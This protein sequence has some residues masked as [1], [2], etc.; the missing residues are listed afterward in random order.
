MI[1]FPY[2]LRRRMMLVNADP[3]FTFDYSGGFTDNRKADGT[4]KVK[5]TSSGTLTILTGEATVSA[6]ILGS[7]GGA[8]LWTNTA[9]PSRYRYYGASG[10]GGG[11]QTI[12]VTL[13]AGDVY[14]I[15]IGSAGAAKN[16]SGDTYSGGSAGN[17][18]AT[19]A[20][21]K[22][23]KGGGG[24]KLG[25]S[26]SGITAGTG[27]SPGGKSG[28][29]ST[30]GNTSPLSLAGGSPNGGAVSGSAKSGSKGY[31]EITFS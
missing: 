21:G 14:E 10:G 8:V 11:N 16:T 20:F 9:S 22:T 26:A 1:S 24:A 30:V 31:V 5:F 4:G 27:G 12:T 29:A 18:G 3:G 13:K 17:G 19:T 7:G 6:Y 2:V 25:S 15:T 23:S 28:V